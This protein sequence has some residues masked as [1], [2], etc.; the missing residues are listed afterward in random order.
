MKMND[1]IEVFGGVGVSLYSMHCVSISRIQNS[2]SSAKDVRVETH[3]GLLM[4]ALLFGLASAPCGPS[5][6]MIGLR[7]VP[8]L[9]FLP[10]LPFAALLAAVATCLA[11]LI[12]AFLMSP[13]FI[14]A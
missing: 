11:L 3:L 6:V 9:L 7:S 13:P 5:F 2:P 12:A 10:P 8:F 14:I 1:L 4:V